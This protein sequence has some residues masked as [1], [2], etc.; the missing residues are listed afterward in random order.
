MEMFVNESLSTQ[1]KHL[2]EI[3]EYEGDLQAEMDVYKS[4]LEELFAAG[5]LKKT[6]K[7][8]LKPKPDTWDSDLD[9]EWGDQPGALIHSDVE[10]EDD[11]DDA[12]TPVP[13]GRGKA[14]AKKVVAKKAPVTKSA[15]GKKRAVEEESDEEDQDVMLLDSEEDSGLFVKSS[16]PAARKAAAP[17]IRKAA[18]APAPKRGA[19]RAATQQSK[20]NFSQASQPKAK[21]NAVKSVI[22]DEISDDD[23]AFEPAPSTTRPTR[24][25][26]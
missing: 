8:K 23:E 5:H 16:A 17:T 10:D 22:E 20:L 1:V 3:D 7:I 15:R 21:G 25:R 24:S 2:M 9:G 18:A 11:E 19:A 12:A 6:R 26:R 13:T 14:A 4:K